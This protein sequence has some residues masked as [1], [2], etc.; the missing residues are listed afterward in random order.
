MRRG[1]VS[2]IVQPR[3]VSCPCI[4]GAYRGK[5]A[6]VPRVVPAHV[7]LRVRSVGTCARDAKC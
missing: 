7:L 4:P 3:A 2:W 5:E 6:P 1:T